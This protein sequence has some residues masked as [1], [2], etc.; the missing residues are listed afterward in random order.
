MAEIWT[1]TTLGGSTYYAEIEPTMGMKPLWALFFFFF[2]FST[3]ENWVV[4]FAGRRNNGSAACYLD[5]ERD[6]HRIVVDG[7]EHCIIGVPFY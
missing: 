2:F 7:E 4:V 3:R 6:S 5:K 1:S